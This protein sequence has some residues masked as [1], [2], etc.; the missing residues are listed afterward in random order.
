[1]LTPRYQ[2]RGTLVRPFKMGKKSLYYC[3]SKSLGRGCPY[4]IANMVSGLIKESFSRKRFPL[5]FTGIWQ[6][7]LLSTVITLWGISR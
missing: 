5:A 6:M 1:M 3:F 4:Q 7:T 2:A